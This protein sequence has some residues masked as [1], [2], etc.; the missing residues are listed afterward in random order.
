M[1]LRWVLDAVSMQYDD[2]YACECVFVSDYV[3]CIRNVSIFSYFESLFD[4]ATE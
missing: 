3:N 1:V 2:G 4:L